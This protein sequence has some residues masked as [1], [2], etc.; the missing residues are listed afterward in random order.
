MNVRNYVKCEVCQSVTMLKYQIGWLKRYP[1][2]YKCGKCGITIYGEVNLNH[3]EVTHALKINNAQL[4]DHHV[5]SN[6][7]L[8]IS[9]EFLTEKM[10]KT[11]KENYISSLFSPFIKEGSMSMGE[12]FEEFKERNLQFLY[13]IDNEWGVVKR[14]YELYFDS[15][16]SYLSSEIRKILNDHKEFPLTGNA[17]YT[18]ALHRIFL[19]MFSP[20]ITVNGY[21]SEISKKIYNELSNF[22]STNVENF[23][24]LLEFF[25][26]DF[27][28]FESKILSLLE[29][30]INIYKY[31][32]PIFSLEF[33]RNPLTK[34]DIERLGL[35]TVSFEELKNFYVDGYES[36]IDI[37]HLVVALNNLKY[38]N[39]FIK[40]KEISTF[41]NNICTL[42]QYIYDMRNKGNKL[43]FLE[44]SEFFGT[45]IN[46]SLD[47]DIRNAIGHNTYIV[48]KNSQII[49]F[50]S[51][52][53]KD[54][55]ELYLIEFAQ[56][57]FNIFFSLINMME[58]IYQLKL[59][60]YKFN[61]DNQKTKSIKK[62]NR[63]KLKKIKK[64][65]RM[66]KSSK[67]KNR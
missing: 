41:K 62:R 65:K 31:L 60:Y 13:L 54:K 10:L 11:T 2:S 25:S 8:Q 23:K 48:D 14:I 27:K 33:R 30:F 58:L 37:S 51:F 15:N 7:I 66:S 32:I 17:G 18:K 39:D 56:Y 26:Q 40:M 29:Y 28:R 50:K 43:Y 57:C 24:E 5:E 34:E 44:E 6:F 19:L 55:K 20:I 53:N 21:Y 9:G 4:L 42:N 61:N 46:K 22:L 3:E 59:I 52:N 63:V 36:L 45:L 16:F 1:L 35:T 49:T 38:R 12:R 47:N 64:K 67:R